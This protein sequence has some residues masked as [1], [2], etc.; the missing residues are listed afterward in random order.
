MSRTILDVCVDAINDAEQNTA[1]AFALAVLDILGIPA[2]G[3]LE[4][5]YRDYA[6]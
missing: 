4:D 5:F 2:D 3:A 6:S 1:E